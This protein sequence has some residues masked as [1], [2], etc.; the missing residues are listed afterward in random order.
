[1]SA[2]PD[3]PGEDAGWR[4]LTRVLAIE[5]RNALARVEL[6]ASELGR[7]ESSPHARERIATI[8]EAVGEIEALLGR[9]DGVTGA[10]ARRAWP[11]VPIGPVW[12][13]LRRRLGA[14]LGP[15]G[16]EL[17]GEGDALAIA[18]CLPTAALERLLCV[19]LR[20]LSGGLRARPD[21]VVPRRIELGASDA[22]GDVRLWLTAPDAATAE[23]DDDP[24]AAVELA[25]QGAEWGGR[26]FRERADGFERVG[27]V[28]PGESRGAR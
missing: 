26:C 24:A 23:R 10:G 20:T 4:A 11:P 13:A 25:V 22:D 14:P 19:L 2:F 12:S 7:F 18:V 3:A 9:I 28:L 17:G 8:R 5:G 16:V 6:A 21:A 1:M 15:R 27:F